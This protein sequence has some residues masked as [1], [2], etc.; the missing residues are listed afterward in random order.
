MSILG[1]LR[2]IHRNLKWLILFP[3]LLALA[4]LLFTRNMEREYQ[5]SATVYTG[6]ASGYKITD[7]EA[8]EK[9][10]FFAVNN[11]FDNL[12]NT[13]K[14]RETVEEVAIRLLAQHLLL[15]QSEPNILDETGFNRLHELLPPEARELMIVPGDFQKT[16]AR[17]YRI[18]DSTTKNIVEYRS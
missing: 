8:A 4:T 15:K 12:I 5:S 1:F 2:I 9:I 18:K 17:I 10:D 14:S 6:L 7:E 13:V 11:A 3:T 16:V